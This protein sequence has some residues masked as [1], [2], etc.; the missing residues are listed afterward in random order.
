MRIP[1]RHLMALVLAGLATATV[2][3]A[4]PAPAPERRPISE[5]DLFKFVW[6]ADPQISPDGSQIAFV[7]VSVDEKAD[8]YDTAIWIVPTDGSG[9]PRRLTAGTRDT[10]PRWSADGRQLA[11]VR[12]IEK[13]G[14]PQPPQ[15]HA[16]SLL[17]GESRP[18]TDIPRGAANP[19]WSP[20]GK[21]IAFTSQARVEE[22]SPRES[23][24][25]RLRQAGGK[26][27]R[28]RRQGHHRSGLSRQRHRRLRLRGA[29]PAVT[30]LDCRGDAGCH[31]NRHVQSESP[32]ASFLSRTQS[33]RQTVRRSISCPT[34]AKSRT[35]K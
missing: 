29:R 18:V 21:S 27:A 20:D 6:I 12:P 32:P 22:V 17:G 4:Q 3:A 9:A 28:I 11:F 23:A 24:E 34:G 8:Q 35:T 25:K 31:A 19:A 14:R 1:R 2:P 16:M 13:D 30:S 7:R 15:I 10:S 33:G 5:K 26:N